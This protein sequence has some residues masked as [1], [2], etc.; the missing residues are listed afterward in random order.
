M[1][2]V[3]VF[4]FVSFFRRYGKNPSEVKRQAATAIFD[5]FQFTCKEEKSKF[6]ISSESF[7]SMQ[8]V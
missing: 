6:D 5:R 8:E 4:K 2:F 1:T 7:H 3:P